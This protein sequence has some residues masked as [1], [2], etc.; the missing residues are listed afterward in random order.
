MII[1]I[2]SQWGFCVVSG[3]FFSSGRQL[4]RENAHGA[5][6]LS[7][8]LYNSRW[9]EV[10][11]DGRVYKV[12]SAKKKSLDKQCFQNNCRPY[13]QYVVK[14]LPVENYSTESL[15]EKSNNDRD[16]RNDF[17]FLGLCTWTALHF[18]PGCFHHSNP[19]I[20]MAIYLVSCSLLTWMFNLDNSYGVLPLE[21]NPTFFFQTFQWCAWPKVLI[22]P[23]HGS[24]TNLWLEW[25]LIKFRCCI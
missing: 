20:G 18:R 15:P 16:D 3:E 8:S 7:F 13:R 19:D 12:F 1:K 14:S 21:C 2:L 23:F 5:S 24:Y 10:A 22:W 17:K 11:I 9:C 6:N 25:W 4:V